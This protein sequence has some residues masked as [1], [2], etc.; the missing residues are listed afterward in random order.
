MHAEPDPHGTRR[1]YRG[2]V[3]HFTTG[4]AQARAPYATH[5]FDDGMLVVRDGYVESCG[6]AAATLAGLPPDVPV[7]DLRGQWI[8]PGFIDTHVH[9]AQTAIIAS[10]GAQ[11][12]DW[13]DQYTYPAERRF[14]DPVHAREAADFF[15]TEL[16]RNGTTSAVVFPTVHKTSVDAL[17]EAALARNLRMVTG[18][19]M[20][21]R[22]CPEFLRDTAQSSYDDSRALIECWH[23]RGRLHYAVTPRFAP[24]STEAQ[25]Q[26]A[27]RL[28]HEYPGLYVQ[29]HV[30]ENRDE[31]RWAAQ[32]FPGARS[33][34]DVY[35]HYGLLGPRA[36]YAHCIHLDT[37][38]RTRM[39]A[40]GAVMSFCATSN[41][42]LGSGLFDRDAANA[43]GAYVTFGTDVAG[44]T[45][46][47]MLR[48]MHEAYKVLQLKGQTLTAG[49][50][51]YL[52]TRGAA[53][54]LGLSDRIGSFAPGTEAD[55]I[56]LDP[57]ATPLLSRR[58]AMAETLAERLFALMILGDDRTIAATYVQGVLA[59]QRDADPR[60]CR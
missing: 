40:T 31:V 52:A 25:L 57:D 23:G 55:F 30:A 53:N 18:K 12:L 48:T 14:S 11:L 19:V 44:G 13:L 46:F 38:D 36:V 24:T 60:S 54:A 8:V 9:Y 37:A 26:L 45:S 22:N 16:L 17:F 21:D 58:F 4:S 27:G 34:L 1:A 10:Y 28:A 5:F 47:S 6:P 29:S 51:F 41:L 42:F 49:D 33:Y 39:G 43:A 59:Y 56:V 15:L 7:V 20:M 50:A 32:L 2:S 3:L 35:D